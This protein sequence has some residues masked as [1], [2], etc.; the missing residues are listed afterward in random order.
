MSLIYANLCKNIQI[1]CKV[2]NSTQ[3][4][5][6]GIQEQMYFHVFDIKTSI[7]AGIGKM[8]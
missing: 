2:T 5:T 3:R 1:W 8:S 6:N 4:L 7:F